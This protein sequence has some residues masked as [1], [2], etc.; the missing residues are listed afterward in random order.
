MN[1]ILQSITEWGIRI[2]EL[3]RLRKSGRKN[4][5]DVNH[6]DLH[7]LKIR[8]S[9]QNNTVRIGKLKP[10]KAIVEIRVH[11]E[12]NEVTLGDN[13]SVSQSLRI[14]A[15]AAHPNMGPVQG[16]KI[17]IGTGCSCENVLMITYNSHAEIKIGQ[18]CMFSF[19]INIY[20]TDGHPILDAQSRQV[21]NRVRNL[22]IGNHVWV[23]ANTTILKNVIIG[24]ESIIGWG[25]V[26]SGK[27]PK[28]NCI[29][30][31]NPAQV[32]REGVTWQADGASCG[33]IANEAE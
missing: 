21:I 2:K 15:G 11:G 12:G 31:G 32:V 27:F 24:N 26:V 4:I 7:R 23:G 6:A 3:R 29:I 1:K 9:G 14:Y 30:A 16:V 8:I 20:H 22:S 25:S 10:G 19:G 17:E 28:D 5:I 13:I 18:N 33:Y